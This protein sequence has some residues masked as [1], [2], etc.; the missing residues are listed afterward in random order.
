MNPYDPHEPSEE[1]QLD[2]IERKLDNLEGSFLL[3]ILL[4]AMFTAAI[5][6]FFETVLPR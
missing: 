2:R 3:T 1:S 4:G 6:M 5:F